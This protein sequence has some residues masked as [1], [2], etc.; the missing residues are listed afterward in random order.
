MWIKREFNG[1]I[2]IEKIDCFWTEEKLIKGTTS[3]NDIV[4]IRMYDS[5]EK[6][7]NVIDSLKPTDDSGEIELDN[8]D[9]SVSER[10]PKKKQLKTY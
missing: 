7:K 9:D 10:K 2:I 5:E 3:H 1:N 4:T 6:A 8:D